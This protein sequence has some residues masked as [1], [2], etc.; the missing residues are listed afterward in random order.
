MRGL[1]GYVVLALSVLAVVWAYNRFSK[2][3]IATLGKEL[4]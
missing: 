4:K 2:D 1:M 3:G